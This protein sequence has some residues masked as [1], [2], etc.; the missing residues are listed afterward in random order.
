LVNFKNHHGSEK[1]IIMK[2]MSALLASAL[3]IATLSG[4]VSSQTSDVYSREDA[5]RP[6]IVNSGTVLALRPVTIEGT[7]SLIGTG[8]G[9]LIGGI[10]GSTVG[11]GKGRYLGA[12]AGAGLGGVAGNFGEERLTRQNGVEITVREDSGLARAYVQ[13]VDTNQI[14]R[15]GDR[16]RIMTVN[17]QTRVSL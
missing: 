6:Q 7:H 8:V 2:K 17:G 13:A 5:R 14:F 15:V 12:I 16:V 4:C 11:G 1:V 3:M 9:A 10:A